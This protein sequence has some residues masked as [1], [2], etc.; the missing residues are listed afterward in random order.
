MSILLLYSN[1]KVTTTD[2]ATIDVVTT[3]KVMEVY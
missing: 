1:Y 2:V 3:V